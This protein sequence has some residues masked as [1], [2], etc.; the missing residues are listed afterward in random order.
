MEGW[1]CHRTTSNSFLPKLLRSIFTLILLEKSL[2]WLEAMRKT[3]G[4]CHLNCQVTRCVASILTS[5]IRIFTFA[6][7]SPNWLL[8][9][10]KRFKSMWRNPRKIRN[11]CQES[12][13]ICLQWQFCS[14]WF[15][16]PGNLCSRNHHA[17]RGSGRRARYAHSWSCLSSKTFG[18]CL[19]EPS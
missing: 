7:T 14:W 8:N 2:L 3:S 1:E 10:T 12:H 15:Y 4:E 11:C 9:L 17:A 19:L 16:P 18:L 5:K 13:A 6:P